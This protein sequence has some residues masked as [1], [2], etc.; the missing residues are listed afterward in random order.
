MAMRVPNNEGMKLFQTDWANQTKRSNTLVGLP[1]GR[2]DGKEVGLQ[3]ARGMATVLQN[4]GPHYSYSYHFDKIEK[5]QEADK[6]REVGK[7]AI[8]CG[9][10]V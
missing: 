9:L 10:R 2:L 3:S 6:E 8:M 5:Q 1:L 4:G 7:T